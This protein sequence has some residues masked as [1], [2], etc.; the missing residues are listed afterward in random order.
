MANINKKSQNNASKEILKENIHN[1]LKNCY[2]EMLTGIFG[3]KQ[4]LT[5]ALV[6]TNDD[7]QIINNYYSKLFGIDLNT[8]IEDLD[9]VHAT[10]FRNRVDKF[11]KKNLENF[12]I[13]NFNLY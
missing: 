7:I 5:Q 2:T 6:A 12:V 9:E 8:N 10:I 13:F 3:K 4:P 1:G 11:F